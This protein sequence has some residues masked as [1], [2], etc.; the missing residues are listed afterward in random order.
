[1][2]CKFV[3]QLSRLRKL[4]A[5]SVENTSMFDSFKEYLHVERQVEMGVITQYK[6]KSEKMFSVTLW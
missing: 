2:N 5:E 6:C 3:A 4:S 1:M